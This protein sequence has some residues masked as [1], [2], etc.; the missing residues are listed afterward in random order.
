M[1]NRFILIVSV[2]NLVEYRSR[3]PLEN[4]LKLLLLNCKFY[5][6]PSFYCVHPPR[7][8]YSRTF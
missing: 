1:T 5:D 2:P 4:V 7:S 3:S 8:G 6:R